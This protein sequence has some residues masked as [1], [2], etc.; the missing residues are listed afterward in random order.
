MLPSLKKAPNHPP[1]SLRIKR[2]QP[3]LDIARGKTY[4]PVASGEAIPFPAVFP[5][6]SEEYDPCH[7]IQSEN[8]PPDG[9][10]AGARTMPCKRPIWLPAPIAARKFPPTPSARNADITTAGRSSNRRRNKPR[11]KF[12]TAKKKAVQMRPFLFGRKGPQPGRVFR[13]S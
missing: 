7:H 4:N 12:R 3:L 2:N 13:V 8:I 6:F 11:S 5:I 10:I 1:G 9:G